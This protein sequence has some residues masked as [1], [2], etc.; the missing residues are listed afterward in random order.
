MS[1]DRER[2]VVDT[3]VGRIALEARGGLVARVVLGVEEPL[4]APETP[5]LA[6][7]IQQLE[8]YFGGTRR[9]FDLPLA[10]PEKTTEFQ[11]RV[12]R[13]LRAIP[14]GETRSYGEVASELAT[15]P[16]AVGGACHRN[17]LP[18]LVP[19]HRVVAKAGLGGYSGDW[20]CGA[21]ETIKRKLLALEGADVAR[22]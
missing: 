14:F 10:P 4:R 18:I 20:E 17:P 2:T 12:W 9:A 16:R 21:S 15:S 1:H 7:A 13:A 8:Q 19:C 5:V 3:P 11:E 6:R 22:R